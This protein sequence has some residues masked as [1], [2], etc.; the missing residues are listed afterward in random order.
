MLYTQICKV[1]KEVLF[2]GVV[3]DRSTK[4]KYNTRSTWESEL[5][6][7]SEYLY[8]ITW[9]EFYIGEMR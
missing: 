4:Q 7:V 1:I 9:L 2:T 8:F 5:V 6:G 3:N